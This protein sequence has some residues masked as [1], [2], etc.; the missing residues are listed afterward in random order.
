MFF[1]NKQIKTLK[2][3]VYHCPRDHYTYFLNLRRQQRIAYN[4]C[5]I[6]A[7]SLELFSATNS[8]SFDVQATGQ[9]FCNRTPPKPSFLTSTSKVNGMLDR[10]TRKPLCF[11]TLARIASSLAVFLAVHTS[12]ALSHINADIHAFFHAKLDT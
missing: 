5:S 10:G 9:R 12:Y 11:R 6:G 3:S 4:T 8:Y 2:C 7:I 1:L